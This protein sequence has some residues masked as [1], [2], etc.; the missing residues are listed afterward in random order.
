MQCSVVHLSLARSR[1]H[2]LD[3]SQHVLP[4]EEGRVKEGADGGGGE[5]GDG[6]HGDIKYLA[7]FIIMLPDQLVLPD[8]L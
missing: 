3:I 4:L 7:Q 8:E 1:L 5:G 2:P 6:K